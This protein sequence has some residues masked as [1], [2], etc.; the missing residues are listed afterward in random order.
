M[1]ISGTDAAK[2]TNWLGYLDPAL[3]SG[4]WFSQLS[5]LGDASGGTL[6][7]AHEFKPAAQ[8]ANNLFYSLESFYVELSLGTSVEVTLRAVGITTTFGAG[9]RAI[10]RADP[11]GSGSSSLR[12]DEQRGFRG[13]ILGQVTRLAATAARLTAEIANPG[14]GEFM[15]STVMGYFWGPEAFSAQGGPQRPSQGLFTN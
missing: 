11:G 1:S 8:P 6:T 5:Q 3:P 15:N 14:V 12:A 13:I 7:I 10:A 4:V 9:W 2:V